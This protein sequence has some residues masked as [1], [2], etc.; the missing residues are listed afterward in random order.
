MIIIINNMFGS[1]QP[2]LFAITDSRPVFLREYSTNHY[3]VGAYFIA[4]LTIEFLETFLQVLLSMLITYW[5]IGYRAN[6]MIFLA[7]NFS[8]AFNATAMSVLL[9]CSV[10]DSQMGQEVMPLIFIPQLLFA[11]FFVSTDLLPEFLQWVPYICTMT[12]AVKLAVV[13]EF[14]PCIDNEDDPNSFCQNIF[15]RVQAE[16]NDVW[17]YW[18][19]SVLIFVVIRLLALYALKRKASV[20]Y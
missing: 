7:I 20:F 6:F 16:K 3:S 8:V 1:A 9:G 4:R 2:V 11:G 19:V 12:Y 17:W 10:K 5:M 18:L 13:A 14:S 15:D